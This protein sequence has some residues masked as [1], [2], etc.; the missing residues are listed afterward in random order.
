MPPDA[1]TPLH[2]LEYA[3]VDVETT[4]TAADRGDRVTEVA[5]VIVR[6]GVVTD[7]FASLVRPGRPIPPFIVRL[8]GITEAMVATA[9][10]F[11]AIAP[12]LHTT[13]TGRI[14]VAH[15]AAFDWAFVRAELDRAIGEVPEVPVLCTVRLA[16]RLLSHLPRRNLDAVTAHFGV[17][18]DARH[19][20]LGDAA[21]TA[22][23][24]VRLLDLLGQEGVHT[25]GDLE[26]WFRRPV[27]P[28]RAMPGPVTDFRIA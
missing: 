2:A 14:F 10:P 8:T 3:V 7:T 26:T 18:I 16:R 5:A 21:A 19:R 28:R 11:A 27:R 13:L 20:A 22:Q 6:D 15:N 17:S 1:T 12:V 4:G 25:W 23:V 24:L 9:P